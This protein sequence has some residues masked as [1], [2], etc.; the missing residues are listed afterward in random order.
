MLARVCGSARVIKLY[1][2]LMCL[3]TYSCE[4]ECMLCMLLILMWYVM[5]VTICCSWM[6]MA[7]LYE[8]FECKQHELYDMKHGKLFGIKT[9]I[10]ICMKCKLKIRMTWS[11]ERERGL[12]S[13]MINV[14]IGG[15]SCIMCVH[16]SGGYPYPISRVRT[17]TS[18]GRTTIV[19]LC[20]ALPWRLLVLTGP[21]IRGS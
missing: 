14:E 19:M 12:C 17:H 15:T 7:W 8:I 3:S 18:N 20:I 16:V 5:H 13:L 1:A 21:S 6:I 4:R 2:S 9:P 11:M 10:G